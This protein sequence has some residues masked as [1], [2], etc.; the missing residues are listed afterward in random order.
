MSSTISL[1]DYR[2]ELRRLGFAW[3]G[4]AK[5]SFADLLHPCPGRYF[6]AIVDKKKRVR[7]KETIAGLVAWREKFLAQK[8]RE[9]EIAALKERVAQTIA[10]A[11]IGAARHTLS[12]AAAIRQLAEDLRSAR[13]ANEG[14]TDRDMLVLGWT[15]EQLT[16]FGPLA[17]QTAY[18]LEG[19][20]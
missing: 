14:P 1:S 11:V 5:Q 10:P 20:R 17:C 2:R 19:G 16:E 7:R 3:L 8:R 4:G 13:A 15:K 6:S 18:A 9:A 12:D